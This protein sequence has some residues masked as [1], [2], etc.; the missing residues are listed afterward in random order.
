[1]GESD[2]PR[3]SSK[4]FIIT[5]LTFM[6][7]IH[8]E[9]IFVCGVRECSNFS[10]LHVAVQFS[11]YHLLKKE[12]FFHCIVSPPISYINL[13]QLT[14]GAQVFWVFYPVPPMYI[15]FVPVPYWHH[16]VL[17]T[18]ALQYSLKSGSLDPPVPFFFLR[19]ALDIWDLLCFQTNFQIFCSNG[20]IFHASGLE[21]L[22][23]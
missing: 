20:M 5:T 6:S 11:Q 17:M 10:L 14:I 12:S 23:L 18:L 21:K 7:L 19:I 16:T 22:L 4:S 9:F 1:M 2:Q 8:F 3:F 13:Y 15:L